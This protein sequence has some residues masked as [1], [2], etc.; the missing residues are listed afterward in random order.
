M[1]RSR[2]TTGSISITGYQL[3]SIDIQAFDTEGIYSAST[4]VTVTEGADS[5]SYQ[6]TVEGDHD[7]SVLA[8]ASVLLN[9]FTNT[10]MLPVTDPVTV[11][12]SESENDAVQLDIT[13]T[14]AISPEPSL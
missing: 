3:T 2:I 13:M 12:I 8:E 11:P 14:P 5:I 1:N 9:D 7:Y 6:L 10:T 4:S